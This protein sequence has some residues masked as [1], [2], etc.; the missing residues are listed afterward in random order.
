[1]GSLSLRYDRRPSVVAGASLAGCRGREVRRVERGPRRRDPV[2]GAVAAAG[3]RGD[4]GRAV[5]GGDDRLRLPVQDDVVHAEPAGPDGGRPVRLDAAVRRGRQVA[6]EGGHGAAGRGPPHLQ[7]GAADRPGVDVPARRRRAVRAR[8]LVDQLPGRRLL[9]PRRLVDQRARHPRRRLGQ[10]QQ[11]LAARWP[12]GGRPADRL[13]AAARVRH[14]R[15]RHP[16]RLDEHAGD[17]RRPERGL[18]L[19]LGRARQP[20][21]PHPVHRLLR[22]HGRRPGRAAPSRR[23]T[24]R[25]P[26]PSSSPAT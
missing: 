19:R 5:A 8:R 11:V 25:S 16:G 3:A 24:C 20:L 15:R 2:L 7:D 12:A 4:R 14:A 6:A 22:V 18:D 21:H 1:M 9:R 26:S 17:R 10:R 13:R 23:S